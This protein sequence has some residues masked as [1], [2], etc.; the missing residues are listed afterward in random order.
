MAFGGMG[1]FLMLLGLA[2][3]KKR[4]WLPIYLSLLHCKLFVV[5]SILL[6][7]VGSIN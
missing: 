2:E 6:L 3:L 7:M 4:I 5:R 1:L